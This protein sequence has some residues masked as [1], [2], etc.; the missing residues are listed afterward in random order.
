MGEQLSQAQTNLIECLKY[1]K[2]DKDAII[3]IMLLVPQ[4]VQIAELAEY[5]LEHPLA[6]ESDI[7]HKAMEISN[8]QNQEVW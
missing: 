3:T 6:T 5:L 2:I 4:D 7:L 1:L 8:A